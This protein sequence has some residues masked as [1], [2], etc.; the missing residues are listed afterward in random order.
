MPVI[1]DPKTIINSGNA[2]LT[3]NGQ[4]VIVFK[5]KQEQ[6]MEFTPEKLQEIYM[7]LAV[8]RKE[9]YESYVSL[10]VERN[11]VVAESD[12]LLQTVESMDTALSEIESVMKVNNIE[13]PTFEVEDE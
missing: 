7:S 9:T 1:K 4:H 12:R 13:V 8:Q 5:L 6:S 2:I 10:L 3:K 11:K